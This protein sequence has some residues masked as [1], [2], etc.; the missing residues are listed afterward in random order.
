MSTLPGMDR[1]SMAMQDVSPTMKDGKIIG[2]ISVARDV[3]NR[4][5]AEAALKQSE[6]RFQ[7]L[8]DNSI[9]CVYVLDLEGKFIDANQATLNLLGF[10]REDIPN[11]NFWML[12][13]ADQL[14][15]AVQAI[16]EVLETG[17][18]RKTYECRV[19]G[20]DGRYVDVETSET[21]VYHEG[22]P[23]SILGVARD[24][25]ERKLNFDRLRKAMMVATVQA[26]A[27]VVETR[28]PYTAGHQRRVAD[29][30]RSIATEM[31][32][33]KNQIEGIR[34]AATIHDIGEISIPAEILSKPS[35]LTDLEYNLI[36]VHAQSGYDIL[37]DIEFP[38]PV[39]RMVLEH[40]ER[41]DGSGYPNGLKGEDILLESEF[42]LWLML[43]RP[44]R[45]TGHIVPL[46]ELMQQWRR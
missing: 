5:H 22:K 7:S 38:W 26:M 45:H 40:H 39:A 12:M 20:K 27:T 44:W 15:K 3:T 2:L 28:D 46:L 18:G 1:G 30:A 9:E 43:W 21:V 19:K 36:K 35:K 24:I 17:Y 13:D 29:L 32:L 31:G 37:K 11:I 42:L 10:N 34:T 41:I 4:V 16:S 14:P 8:F 25:T 6:E 23:H 33:S